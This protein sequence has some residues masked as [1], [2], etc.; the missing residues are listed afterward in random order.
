MGKV[1]LA[2]FLKTGQLIAG[3]ITCIP[4]LGY[5]GTILVGTGDYTITTTDAFILV[6]PDNTVFPLLGSA[7][8]TNLDTRCVLTVVTAHR[9]RRQFFGG[10]FP[11]K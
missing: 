10:I 8:D 3:E 2:R 7:G 1:T 6:N 11:G 4:V 5:E 9:E